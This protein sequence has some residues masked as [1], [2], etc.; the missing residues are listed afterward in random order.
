MYCWYL[1]HT[2]LDN[3]LREPGALTV[4]GEKIDLGRIEA[5][6][7]IY[8]S[9][10]DHIVP[11]ASAYASVP[12]LSGAQ[13]RTFVLGA[14]G[15]IAGVINPAK[16]NKRSHWIG[17]HLPDSAED[18]LDSATERPGSWWPVWAEWLAGHGGAEI[19]APKAYGRKGRYAEIEPAPGRYV[20]AKA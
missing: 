4:C 14:S 6:F 10:E 12:L 5:P 19:A 3:A 1:R 20:K 8:G 2:Y 15:H 7:F 17:E 18:W 9:R 13:D 11:W 16:K